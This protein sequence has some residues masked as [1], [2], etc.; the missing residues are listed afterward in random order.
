MNDHHC[1][2]WGMNTFYKNMHPYLA[3][4]NNF[5]SGYDMMSRIP[6]P[7][8][9]QMVVLHATDRQILPAAH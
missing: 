2:Y 8:Q 3:T 1:P 5:N 9:S 6:F 4:K 7:L